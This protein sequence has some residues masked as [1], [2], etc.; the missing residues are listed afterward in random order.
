MN[1]KKA[2]IYR[3]VTLEEML[4]CREK[5]AEQQKELLRRFSA[6]VISFT[7]N[8]PG[9]EKTS[10]LIERGF[11]GMNELCRR[12]PKNSILFSEYRVEATGCEAF[13]AVDLP[14]ETTKEICRSIEEETPLGRLFDLDVIGANG[15]KFSRTEERCCIICGK[16]G[17]ACAASRAHSV[18][19][20]WNKV[21]NILSYHFYDS[22]PR[23]FA[24]LAV[25]ALKNEVLTTPKP[26]LVDQRNTGSHKDMNLSLFLASAEALQDYFS[27]AVSIGTEYAKAPPHEA[28]LR[29]RKAGLEAESRMFAVT[30]GVN[31]HKGAIYSLGVLCGAIGR[32]WKPDAP[33]APLQDILDEAKKLTKKAVLEDFAAS[34]CDTAGKKLYNTLGLTGI[35]GEAA[36]GFPSVSHCALP[37]LT[38][39]LQE[40]KS[41]WEAGSIALLHLIATVED[42]TL[43]H[44]G[45]K[46]GAAFAKKAARE[47][48]EASPH[49][50]KEA[51]EAL[52]DDFIQKNLSPGGC[53]DLLAVSFFLNSL[54]S[55]S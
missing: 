35:R 52:D 5:R 46:E 44:R 25:Q 19:E 33:I 38:K 4:L 27:I 15:E 42:T 17:W 11:F 16:K 30:S 34:E 24:R 20:L 3:P 54:E 14:G 53:A 51:L 18:S 1:M 47:L 40:G 13:F 22:D 6:P 10:P 50:A 7:M 2:V 45:G 9:P 37:V 23:N 43:Y 26:G 29:L 21:Q 55:F 31:T 48:L 32:L 39:L 41:L 28:F 8:I 12:L 49:P 36:A